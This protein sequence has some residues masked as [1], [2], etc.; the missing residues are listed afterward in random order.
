MEI[1]EKH[2]KFLS[3]PSKD[4]QLEGLQEDAI[5]TCIKL[6]M[7]QEPYALEGSRSRWDASS[8][9]M[10]TRDPYCF[11]IFA[12]DLT[13]VPGYVKCIHSFH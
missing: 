8:R 5:N 9:L 13:R 3:S 4:D 10:K 2:Q 1:I 7:W 6:I 12:Q 11:E